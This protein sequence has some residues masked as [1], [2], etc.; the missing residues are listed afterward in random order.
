[1][2][3]GADG[4]LM[5][6]YGSVAAGG[7]QYLTADHLG[8]VRVVTDAAG[9]VVERRDYLAFGRELT[10]TAG[11]PRQGVAGYGGSAGLRQ[12][13]TGK[14]RDGETGLDYFGARYYSG[15]REVYESR[16]TVR[17]SVSGEPAELESLQLHTQ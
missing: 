2:V 7:R 14:E 3:Y 5:A 1:M 15:R 4:R 8:S 9:A 17:R 6:E 11:D 10:F 12:Q 13:F 16:R